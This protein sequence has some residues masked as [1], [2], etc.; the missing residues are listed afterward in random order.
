MTFEATLPAAAL[1][2]ATARIWRRK[3]G[4]IIPVET[5]TYRRLMGEIAKALKEDRAVEL[6]HHYDQLHPRLG[7]AHDRL[8]ITIEKFSIRPADRMTEAERMT[9]KEK[10]M[11][12]RYRE[13]DSTG[14]HLP[15]REKADWPA[16]IVATAI[17]AM[18]LAGLIM[19]LGALS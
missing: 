13:N 11:V 1:A 14:S 15:V 2:Q 10:T 3:G 6:E 18:S 5:K 9:E 4:D 16:V 19:I 7:E 17:V 12:E 8:T